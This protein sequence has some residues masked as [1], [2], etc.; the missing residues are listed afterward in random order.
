MKTRWFL[1]ISV[2]AV[3]AIISACSNDVDPKFKYDEAAII[4]GECIRTLTLGFNDRFRITGDYDGQLG[5]MV[6][7]SIMAMSDKVLISDN[8]YRLVPKA[9]IIDG[10]GDD[11]SSV[12]GA[13]EQIYTEYRAKFGSNPDNEFITTVYYRDG[14]VITADKEF[15]GIPAGENLAS[16]LRVFPDCLKDYTP[17]PTIDAPQGYLPLKMAIPFKWWI[18]DLGVVEENVHFEVEMPVKVGM[19]LTLLRDRLTNPDAEMQFRDE[20][21]TAQFTIPR[22]LH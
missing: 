15:A 4:P 3:I 9:S 10:F 11:A 6:E 13:Y 2:I 7:L 5:F 18:G 12:K 19:M 22:N 20:V 1:T 16:I 14:L 21:L 8:V 17:I